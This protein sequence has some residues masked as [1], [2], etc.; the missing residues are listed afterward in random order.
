MAFF[1]VHLLSTDK[2]VFLFCADKK[3]HEGVVC[4]V[5]LLQIDHLF[6]ISHSVKLKLDLHIYMERR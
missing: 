5:H 3:G 2:I 1:F 6:S 4:F